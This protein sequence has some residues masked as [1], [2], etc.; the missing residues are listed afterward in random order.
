[1][2]LQHAKEEYTRILPELTTLQNQLKGLKKK[3]RKCK[4]AFKKYCKDTGS[5]LTVAGKT[6]S[7]K[8][9]EKVVCTLDRVEDYFNASE[10][11]RFKAMN[12]EEKETFST[13]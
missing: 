1:M 11:E 5:S 7:F 12:T 8:T 9:K 2:D 6:F 13:S 3:E 10:V 4:N